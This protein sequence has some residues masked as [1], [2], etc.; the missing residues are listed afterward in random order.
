MS[1]FRCNR[2]YFRTGQTAV[3]MLLAMPTLLGALALGV[4]VSLMYLNWEQLQKAADAAALAGANSLPGDPATAVTT[5]NQYALSNGVKQGE[6]VSSAVAGDDLSITVTLQRTVP[7]HFGNLLGLTQQNVTVKATAGV[8]KNNDNAS[9]LIPIGLSCNA[10]QGQGDC[11]YTAGWYHLK[12]SQVGPGN[13]DP[14]E[15]GG[16]PGA[17]AYRNYMQLGYTGSIPT[18]VPTEP[19]NVVGP[20]GQAIDSRMSRGEAMNPT[21]T[22]ANPPEYDPRLVV[23]PLIQFNDSNGKK[24]VTVVGYAQMWIGGLSGNNN[25]IDLYFEGFVAQPTATASNDAFGLNTPILLQ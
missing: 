5:A 6:I 25:T 7:Y 9:G 20:T 16:T 15:L 3:I 24:P 4:D 14:V 13:W 22:E 19:G 10:G 21:A 12:S 23:V 8:Q 11:N 2:R 18:T 1:R 17:N